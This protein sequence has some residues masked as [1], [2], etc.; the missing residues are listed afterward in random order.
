MAK[1]RGTAGVRFSGVLKLRSGSWSWSRLGLRIMVR[2]MMRMRIRVRVRVRPQLAIP[3]YRSLG[4][5]EFRS[6]QLG[7]LRHLGL[8]TG[9]VRRA[10][11]LVGGSGTP[12]HA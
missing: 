3:S 7:W 8:L 6:G 2:V 4:V 11:Q 1:V 10:V 12:Q 5:A 9:E